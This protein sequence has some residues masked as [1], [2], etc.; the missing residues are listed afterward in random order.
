MK[1]RNEKGFIG[2]G[3]L[4]SSRFSFAN[5]Q[6]AKRAFLYRW[7]WDIRRIMTD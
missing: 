5:C 4:L 2:L 3:K 7:G 1:H 6:E